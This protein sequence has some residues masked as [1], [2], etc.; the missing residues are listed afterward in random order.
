MDAI[1]CV[2]RDFPDMDRVRLQARAGASTKTVARALV[3]ADVRP[4]DWVT[5]YG[6]RAGSLAAATIT[7]GPERTVGALW[8]IAGSGQVLLGGGVFPDG[9][10]AHEYAQRWGAEMTAHGGRL[11]VEHLP[12]P[13]LGARDRAVAGQP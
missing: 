11:Q 1:S 9:T 2:V 10:T 3:P 8:L 6:Q 7:A 12:L 13:A 4:G 5:V